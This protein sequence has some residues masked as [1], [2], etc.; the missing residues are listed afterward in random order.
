MYRLILLLLIFSIVLPV[1]AQENSRLTYGQTV[2]GTLDS[3][4]FRHL[5]SFR[6]AAGENIRLAMTTTDGDLDPYLVLMAPGGN[7]IAISDDDGA[8]NNAVITALTLPSSGDYF[9][10]ATR[11]GQEHGTTEGIYRLTLELITA[12]A[13]SPLVGTSI[14]LGA[15]TTGQLDQTIFEQIFRFE[16]LR[17]QVLNIQ[18]RRTSG[19]LDPLLDL[20][21][22]A[23]QLLIFGDDDPDNANSPN[24][25]IV[26]FTIPTDGVY[27]IRATRYGREGGTTSGSYVLTINEIPV[28]QLGKTPAS[29]RLV[30]YGDVT[31]GTID[32]ETHTRFFRFEGN[33]G[34]VIS[35]I[36]TREG[37]NLAPRV[38]LLDDELRTLSISP[39]NPAVS[40]ARIPGASLSDDGIYYLVVTRYSGEEGTS[41]GEFTLQFNGNPGI[42]AP[43]SLE[44]IY[45]AQ[46]N[47]FIN[48]ERFTELY[49]FQGEA[50][51]RI[52]ITMENIEGDLDPLL[53]LKDSEGKQ[54]TFSDDDIEGTRDAFIENYV[55]PETGVYRLE[56]SRYDN[57]D[58][59]TSGTYLLTIDKVN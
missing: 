33:R 52:N 41:E 7:V 13:D 51:D 53:T 58:G 27:F 29:A 30:S 25:G 24:A 47:G 31:T 23:G 36:V 54:L 15:R 11:F 42:G 4:Q 59:N 12:T 48:D 20:F 10:I 26:N 49:V 56:A 2:S 1:H 22:G 8:S 55:L 37:G 21:D 34:D 18:M 35:A 14:S 32:Q 50:G 57:R 38:S 9:I 3:L 16:A 44:L 5:Y 45:G 39:D 28:D 40:E 17:G 19:N 43:N 46:L 6:G